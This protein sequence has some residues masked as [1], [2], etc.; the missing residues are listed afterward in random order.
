LN[1]NTTIIG[2]S[3]KTAIE[4][5]G[6]I[7]CID[8]L[9]IELVAKSAMELA[10]GGGDKEWP[11]VWKERETLT[12]IELIT[13]ILRFYV[14]SNFIFL[15]CSYFEIFNVIKHWLLTLR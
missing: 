11:K 7:L 15:K 9:C 8:F 13:Y 10:E 3:S 5:L 12:N 1:S 2:C 6:E 14:T 4:K